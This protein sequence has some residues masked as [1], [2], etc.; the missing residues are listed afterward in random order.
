M[1]KGTEIC[2]KLYEE[3]TSYK[4]TNRAD[5]IRAGYSRNEKV[6]GYALSS[7]PE[8]VRAG[9]RKKRY[10]VN[11]NGHPN[12]E[13][14]A[15]YMSPENPLRSVRECG[16]TQKNMPLN[17]HTKKPPTTSRKNAV[18]QLSLIGTPRI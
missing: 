2:E 18:K 8:K 6:G 10:A 17:G 14:H 13:K 11:R 7:N 4:T 16:I 5:K 3:G 12:E 15:C 1:F 9:K